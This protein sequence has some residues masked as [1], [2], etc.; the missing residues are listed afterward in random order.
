[1]TTQQQREAFEA[2]FPIP[3][4]SE[5]K[6]F[7][8]RDGY[9]S[10]IEM[11][12]PTAQAITEAWRGFKAGAEWQAAQ[13]QQ[14]P[15]E[16]G[17]NRYG[18]D[19]AYFRNLFNR[20]LLRPLVDFRP[21]EL[22]RVLARA[23]KTADSEVLQEPEFQAAR[24]CQME[25]LGEKPCDCIELE[26]GYY[27]QRCDCRNSGDMTE[28]QQWCDAANKTPTVQQVPKG[29]HLLPSEFLREYLKL[30][31]E[32]DFSPIQKFFRREVVEGMLSTD[33]ENGG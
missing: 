20:E 33:D 30:L 4:N 32:S 3:E 1:M 6:Y 9:F 18:L 31:E 25:P 27:Q 22:A 15:N 2:D 23:A 7:P 28:A 26:D 19:M 16:H 8:E 24:A 13:A 5:I 11:W 10:R 17:Q 14:V 21:D 29:Q 12:K